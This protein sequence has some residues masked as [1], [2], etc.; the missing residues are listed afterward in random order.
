MRR[1]KIEINQMETSDVVIGVVSAPIRIALQKTITFIFGCSG[2]CLKATRQNPFN[3]NVCLNQWFVVW[4][5]NKASKTTKWP[6]SQWLRLSKVWLGTELSTKNEWPVC[7]FLIFKQLCCGISCSIV[8]NA[9]PSPQGIM[10][11]P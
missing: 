5:T 10:S 4:N 9:W 3:P 1:C 11:P 8:R 2:L 7:G 6:K